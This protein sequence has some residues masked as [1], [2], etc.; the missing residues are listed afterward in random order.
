MKAYFLSDM[1]LGAAYY[2]DSKEREQRVVAFLD[3]IKEDAS[4]IYLLGDVLDYWYEYRYVIPRG[5]VRFFGKLAELSDAGVKIT[6]IIGNHDIW[7][8]DYIPNELGVK[9]VDGTYVTKV[10]DKT[11]MLMAHGDGIWQHSRKFKFLR[12]LFRNR[13]CQRLFSSIHPRWTV[14]FANAWSRHSRMSALGSAT[15]ER[16]EF[17]EACRKK[18]L[19]HIDHMQEFS[20][21]FALSHPECK[22]Y[23]FGHVHEVADRR[24]NSGA[25]MIVLGDWIQRFTYAVFDGAEMH[26]CRFD[27]VRH[28]STI[29]S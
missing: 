14:A 13:I 3:S 4:E 23:L 17:R 28:T 5:F 10:L 16:S 19:L 9:V 12:A 29:L 15:G 18:A 11:T 24:L 8:F 27:P 20:E 21:E 26:L 25:R 2:P 6:W 22:Y 7:I 1:H